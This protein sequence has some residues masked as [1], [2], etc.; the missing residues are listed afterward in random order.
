MGV[1]WV[2]ELG[3]GA[4]W[5]DP[6]ASSV[7]LLHPVKSKVLAIAMDTTVAQRPEMRDIT[8]GLAEKPKVGQENLH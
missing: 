3:N 8:R 2:F 7:E 6:V 4:V 5:I 1:S